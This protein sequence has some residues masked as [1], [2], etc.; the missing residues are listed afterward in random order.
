M[1]EHC[2]FGMR[3]SAS[4]HQS[5][6]APRLPRRQDYKKGRNARRRGARVGRSTS[7]QHKIVVSSGGSRACPVCAAREPIDIT[8]RSSGDEVKSARVPHPLAEHRLSVCAN[9]SHQPICV[10]VC[11]RPERLCSDEIPLD[12]RSGL[13]PPSLDVLER[14]R[15]ADHPEDPQTWTAPS[16]RERERESATRRHVKVKD[17]LWKWQRLSMGAG[18][19]RT[20][21]EHRNG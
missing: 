18:G 15:T 11:V 3:S 19:C 9:E 10:C 4:W 21:S 2:R 16:K 20:A 5:A 7:A 6:W 1:A 8:T 13:W 14:T 12:P 17:R